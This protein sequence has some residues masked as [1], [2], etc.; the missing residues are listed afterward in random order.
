MGFE[1]WKDEDAG[2]DDEESS[3]D[4]DSGKDTQVSRNTEDRHYKWNTKIDFGAPYILVARDRNNNIYS[5]RDK[6]G[7]QVW[8][9]QD[10]WRRIRKDDDEL[11]D[12]LSDKLEVIFTVPNRRRWLEFCNKAIDQ[13]G[14]DPED[15]FDNNPRDLP[16]L[17]KRT[18]FANPSPPDMSRTC[19]ICGASSDSNDCVIVEVDLQA[20]RRVPLCEGHT[21]EEMAQNG[22]LD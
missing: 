1:S 14:E 10:D 3:G 4:N 8:E 18:H 5:H 15:Y 12:E 17:R 16:R 21:V 11:P 2:S 13:H 6:H 20:H 19:R 22:L 7:H 9:D